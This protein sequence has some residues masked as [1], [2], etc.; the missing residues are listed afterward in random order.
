MS[1]AF[2]LYT[3]IIMFISIFGL[4]ALK[5]RKHKYLIFHWKN[6]VFAFQAVR[7]AGVLHKRISCMF[8]TFYVLISVGR[9]GRGWAVLGHS[10]APPGPPSGRHW[11]ASGPLLSCP[12][13]SPGPFLGFL[14]GSWTASGRPPASAPVSARP[15][16]RLLEQIIY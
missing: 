3:L 8:V 14:L 5:R 7:V 6:V 15:P 12:G 10:W 11:G 13:A 1:Y 4:M 16:A 2:S 9:E